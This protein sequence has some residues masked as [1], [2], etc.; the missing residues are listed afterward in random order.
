M[1]ANKTINDI[2][3]HPNHIRMGTLKIPI[4][5]KEFK[6]LVNEGYLF[7]DKTMLI[8][9]IL[10]G[11]ESNLLFTRPRRF[12]KTLVLSML[13]RFF[14]IEY[15]E[16]ETSDDTFK[17]LQISN[18]PQYAQWVDDGI[19]NGFPVIRLDMS[20]LEFTESQSFQKTM[21]NYLRQLFLQRF[22]Y[23][24]SSDSLTDEQ[25]QSLS[26]DADDERGAGLL[27]QNICFSLKMHHGVNPIVLIDEYDDPV[28]GSADY[29]DSTSFVKEYV[30]FLKSAL[31]GN[32]YISKTIV[33]GV[34]K[35]VVKGIFSSFNDLKHI[36]V[37]DLEFDGYFGIVTNEMRSF[38][39]QCLQTR[40][41]HLSP[42]VI[43]SLTNEKFDL[44]SKWFDGYHIGG[45]D[46][47]NPWSAMH[48]LKKNILNDNPVA[49]YWRDTAE[50]NSLVSLFSHVDSSILENVKES[51]IS[52]NRLALD[53]VNIAAPL[54]KKNGELN[55]NDIY[56]LLLSSGYLTSE[57]R[58][59]KYVLTIPNLE[60]R[61]NFDALMS[62]VYCINIPKAI[63]LLGHIIKK[64]SESVRQDLEALMMGG[65]YLDG[66]GEYR[67][68]SWLHDLFAL[69]GYVSITEREC[70]EGR[71]DL[72]IENHGNNPAIIFEF[73]VESPDSD[74]SL[75]ESMKEGLDQMRDNRCGDAP[76]MKNAISLSVA[77][78]KK[79]C[80]VGF[81]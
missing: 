10:D 19:K 9:D 44:A 31:K 59:G 12:G 30:Q 16:E 23:L 72:L 2:V 35:I 29:D 63:D 61:M 21:K 50:N 81:L 6:S 80:S 68:K 39:N 75:D 69:H 51:Y 67:Y 65:S 8:G 18:H 13:D 24:N 78:R 54:W 17:D 71:A 34:Q 74:R 79:S 7:S 53:D 26:F 38:I 37:T 40:Y 57:Y 14:N 77:F 48:F 25:K 45:K 20:V 27:F 55:E 22:A 4:G 5:V 76:G 1:M 73:K 49:P 42:D 47:F 60:V 15:K 33:T 58:D 46:V 62:R 36:G 28:D 3:N 41:Q 66:W 52:G 11:G 43:E 70:G 64:D 32:P 56:S